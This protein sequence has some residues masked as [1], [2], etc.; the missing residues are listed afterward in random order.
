MA[1][2]EDGLGLLLLAD[3]PKGKTTSSS[4]EQSG[5]E[6]AAKALLKAIKRDDAKGVAKALTECF[7]HY[8]DEEE[9]ET[10]TEGEEEE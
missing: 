10:E 4:E 5:M 8:G 7:E 1:K 9:P 2:S 6:L 3:K